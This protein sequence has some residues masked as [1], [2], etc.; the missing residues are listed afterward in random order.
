MT[1][2]TTGPLLLVRDDEEGISE[3]SVTLNPAIAALLPEPLCRLH[4]MVPI[5][6]L[7]GVLTVAG[8]PDSREEAIAVIELETGNEARLLWTDRGD[9]DAAIDQLFATNGHDSEADAQLTAETLVAGG[10]AIAPRLGESL[11]ARGLITEEQLAEAVEEQQRSGG[12]IGQVLVHQ[13]ALEERELQA[14]LAEP[15]GMPTVDLSAY[16]PAEAPRDEIPEPV[17]RRLG[18]VAFAADEGTLY[19]AVPDAL[20][21]EAADEIASHTD[22]EVDYFLAPTV[23][24]EGFLREVNRDGY[25][26]IALS[27]LRERFPDSSAH[28]VVSGGQKVVLALAAIVLIGFLIWNLT[29]TIIFIFAL[30]SIFYLLTALYKLVA[31]FSALNH[32][33]LI[34]I[35]QD[36]LAAMDE[37]TLPV[38]TILVPLFREAAVI[39]YLVQGIE[40]LDYPKA[41]LDVK[42]LCEE[43]DDETI[44]AIRALNLPP[45]FDTVVVPA[46]QPQTKPKACNYGLLAPGANT[47]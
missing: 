1:Q 31:G 42:L 13:G 44:D 39:P 24:I 35:T 16:D 22:R 3:R 28:T 10:V 30:A 29:G 36:D 25:T 6:Y 7:D 37:R 11:A 15:L 8:D 43:D 32:Q 18:V 27:N 33:Y 21:P 46:S 26:A 5:E 20:E 2:Q 9:V 47:S 23:E 14:V 4:H 38:Y 17:A 19:V 34:D 45:H 12:R 40:S 41:R